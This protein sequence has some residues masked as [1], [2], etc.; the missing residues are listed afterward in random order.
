MNTKVLIE[1]YDSYR[2]P[3]SSKEKEWMPSLQVDT[4]GFLQLMQSVPVLLS[5]TQL[6]QI[7]GLEQKLWSESEFYTHIFG[8]TAQQKNVNTAL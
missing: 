1:N 5:P 8:W 2:S 3:A 6:G 7:Q 4:D